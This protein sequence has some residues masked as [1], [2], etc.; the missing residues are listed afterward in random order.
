MFCSLSEARPLPMPTAVCRRP[1]MFC[2]HHPCGCR[3]ASA[4][5]TGL[6]QGTRARVRV[7]LPCDPV[8]QFVFDSRC[9][10]TYSVRDGRPHSVTPF[11]LTHSQMRALSVRTGSAR[12]SRNGTPVEPHLICV[13]ICHCARVRTQQSSV[14]P[15]HYPEGRCRSATS[16]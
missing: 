9:V 3:L 13:A 6:A 4:T 12:Q 8:I 7:K 5:S 16:T 1:A 2:A 11:S 10:R 14:K 15:S